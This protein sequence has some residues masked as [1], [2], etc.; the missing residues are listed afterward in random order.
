MSGPHPH[1]AAILRI[2][3]KTLLAASIVV[4]FP[5]LAAEAIPAYDTLVQEA[6]SGNTSALL[7][8]L[9]EREQEHPLTA[10]QVADW[11]Q[12][13]NWANLDHEVITVWQRYYN[14]MEI[15]VRGEV[16]AAR[17]YRNLKQYPAALT[18]WE[19]ALAREAEN[20]DIRAGLVMTLAD[21][22]QFSAAA[23]GKQ[24]VA[25]A[26][27]AANYEALAYVYRAQGQSWDALFAATHAQE[28]NPQSKGASQFLAGSLSATRLS[29]PALE[30]AEQADVSPEMARRLQTDAAAELVRIAFL[31]TRN[32][33]ERYRVADR[34]LARYDYLLNS[35]RNDPAAQ[36]D[37]RRAR[38][39]RL[40]A[41]LARRHPDDVIREYDAL[42]AD[43]QPV[44]N[45]AR[46]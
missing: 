30:L 8:Y 7:G 1:T 18:R 45:Y 2:P 6:R 36:A 5:A 29:V 32:E 41:L 14:T 4:A 11:L 38:I 17:A 39:D 40:G 44:P 21:A 20:D 12:V 46:R 28:A 26:P 16:A 24:L 3:L 13:A 10:N 15:P 9:R 43:G 19:S 31:P 33:Q 42:S 27:T 23:Q 25:H 34:V 22:R 35:W 37:Y